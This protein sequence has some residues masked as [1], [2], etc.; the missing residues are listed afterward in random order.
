VSQK[1][2]HSKVLVSFV[3][4]TT[5][6]GGYEVNK[7]SRRPRGASTIR[8][9]SSLD[10]VRAVS[11]QSRFPA[12]EDYCGGAKP[13]WRGVPRMKQQRSDSGAGLLMKDERMGKGSVA[14]SR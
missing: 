6:F 4:P 1:L 14:E 13:L 12:L 7:A 5:I 10:G 11:S 8:R 2:H 3:V 9:C